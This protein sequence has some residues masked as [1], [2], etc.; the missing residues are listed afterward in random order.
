MRQYISLGGEVNK[1]PQTLGRTHNFSPILSDA[2]GKNAQRLLH[3]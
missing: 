1:F 2:V 3:F